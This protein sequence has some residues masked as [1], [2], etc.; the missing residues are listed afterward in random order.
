MEPAE[1][2]ADMTAETFAA[3]LEGRHRY[4]PDRG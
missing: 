1:T 4:A 3:A 2:A